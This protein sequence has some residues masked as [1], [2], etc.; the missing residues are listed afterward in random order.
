MKNMN[1]LFTLFIVMFS[2]VI[3]LPTSANALSFTVDTIYDRGDFVLGDG[4]CETKNKKCSLRAAIDEINNSASSCL[5][6]TSPS[7]RDKTVSRMPSSA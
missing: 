6:Y 3:L 4:L 7:P 5:L 2:I 1:H